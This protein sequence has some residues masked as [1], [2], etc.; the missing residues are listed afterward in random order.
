MKRLTFAVAALFVIGAALF[1]WSRAAWSQQGADAAGT[2]VVR[3]ARRDIAHFVKATGVI[4]PRVGAEV[5][6][7][8][9]ASGVV[10]RLY[11]RIGDRVTKGQVL[12]ELDDRDLPARGNE[13]S[14]NVSR[15]DA[16][17][18]Y[19]RAD[20]QRKR[21]LSVNG[22]IARSELDIA[23]RA[24]NVA[25]QQVTA[26]RASL[27]LATTQLGYARI[28]A[29]IGGIVASVSTQEGETVAAS[30]ASPTFVTLI[31]LARLEV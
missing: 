31:D 16:D 3:V 22:V 9:R 10:T 5:R 8:S 14:A 29:P 26:A 13:A 2:Q 27:D 24:A 20:L 19:A 25:E 1:L 15:A 23:Q 6:V 30:F 28:V 4:R 21:D 11:V 17:L 18:D 12:A 7:G